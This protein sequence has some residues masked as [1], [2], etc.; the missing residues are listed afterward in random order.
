MFQF[1]LVYDKWD[2]DLYFHF[3]FLH[4]PNTRIIFCSNAGSMLF[5][6]HNISILRAAQ[7]Q[8]S[9]QQVNDSNLLCLVTK[10]MTTNKFKINLCKILQLREQRTKTRSVLFIHPSTWK[11]HLTRVLL[12]IKLQ[13]CQN[14]S[15]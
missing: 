1:C 8:T 5:C 4:T 6:H 9:S 15:I 13:C 10:W 7:S 3:L 14:L 11:V 12:W 2:T